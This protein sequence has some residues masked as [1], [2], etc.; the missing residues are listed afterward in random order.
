MEPFAVRLDRVNALGQAVSLEKAGDVVPFNR[1]DPLE[2]AVARWFAADSAL[3][4]R[5][6]AQPD[7]AISQERRMARTSILDQLRQALEEASAEAQGKIREGAPIQV[8][9]EPC[10]GAILVRSA[11]LEACATTP[12]PVC[13]AARAQEPQGSYR[14]VDAPEDL[15][16]L[17][18]Y[19]PWSQSGPLQRG[20]DG[21]L[22][23]A[24][25]D[26]RAR[27][28]NVVFTVA[29]APLFRPR[30]ELSEEEVAQFNANLD[31]LGFVFGH[32]LLVMAPGIELQGN[33]PPPLGGENLYAL[34]FGDL[35]GDDMI[36]NMEAGSGGQFQASFP[37][38]AS[39]LAR[40]QAGEVVS[41]TALRVPE[42]EG[43][44]AEAVFT[45]S[46]LQV[47]QSNN[48]GAL[49]QY[50]GGGGLSTDLLALIPPG[51]G[52]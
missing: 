29:V 3:A 5:N 46:L 7:S 27:R 45:L 20:A 14:F 39:A 8:A 31:S 24:R 13:E 16:D 2:D 30:S 50:M 26:A 28:G 40:L 1:A 19:G 15:W 23:G 48:V 44:E 10:V 47:G 11:V 9:A 38:S 6:I 21:N 49:L 51:A 35:S 33:L 37:A 42:E 41:L 25:T 34:H 18:Q 4:V 17:E 22:V 12:S 43:A 36:W 52:G 32:P